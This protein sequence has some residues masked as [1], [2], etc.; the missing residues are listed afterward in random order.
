LLGAER[1]EQQ[2]LEAADATPADRSSAR[3]P[4]R[5]GS[6]RSLSRHVQAELERLI[7]EGELQPGER[8]NEVALAR[9]LGVSRGPV[10]E[11]ARG[12]E[13]SGLVTVIVNRGAFVRTLTIDEAMDIYE[14]NAVIFGLAASQLAVLVT[15]AQ[16]MELQGLVD[17]MDRAS[18]ASDPDAFFDL[19]V[20]FHQ[21]IMSLARNRQA[22]ALY[23]DFTKKLL[24]F[25]RRS[26]DRE[27]NMAQSN[28]EHRGL[29]QAIAAGQSDLARERAENHAR[30][31]RARF[32]GAIESDDAVLRSAADR[33]VRSG[34][35]AGRRTRAEA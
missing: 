22:E 18:D 12:L 29:L 2:R 4:D 31:G 34:L 6:S 7:T 26:F 28:A 10:R 30:A 21:R 20:R 1:M 8:L 13:K 9:R 11:A 3:G 33:R 15:A 17:G 16:A 23:S 35:R 32:L 14:L 19:N 27:G 5:S 25:R 24:L